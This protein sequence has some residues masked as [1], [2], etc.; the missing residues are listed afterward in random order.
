MFWKDITI[1]RWPAE[2]YVITSEE[3]CQKLF[4]PVSWFSFCPTTSRRMK[5]AP[6]ARTPE[7]AFGTNYS[8]AW[9]GKATRRSGSLNMEAGA[10][11]L[12]NA[13]CGVHCGLSKASCSQGLGSWT[14][15]AAYPITE[16]I[17]VWFTDSW[18]LWDPFRKSERLKLLHNNMKKLF[19]HCHMLILT[20]NIGRGYSLELY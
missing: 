2:I 18:E 6:M 17:K 12:L 14:P 16:V 19:A 20:L 3:E 8:G 1:S 13:P 9:V 15:E 11:V 10:H 4:G 7:A 5:M